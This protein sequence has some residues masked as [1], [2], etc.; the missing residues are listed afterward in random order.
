MPSAAKAGQSRADPAGVG[1]HGL[2][3]TC[4]PGSVPNPGS[5]ARLSGVNGGSG[6][7]F[8]LAPLDGNGSEDRRLWWMV[9]ALI[10]E[11]MGARPGSQSEPSARPWL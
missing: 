10:L 5:F 1:I 8:L 4:R 11:L 2:A 9:V 6:P 7:P 3:S